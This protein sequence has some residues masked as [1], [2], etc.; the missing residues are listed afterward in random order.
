MDRKDWG[1]K[2][3]I[4]K[5]SSMGDIIHALPVLATLREHYPKAEI[6]WIVKDKFSD[7][8]KDNPDLTDIISFD[9]NS[10]LQLINILRKRTFDVALDL[11]GLFRSGI[12]AYFSKASH[13]IGFSKINSREL[14]HIFYNHKVTPS[15]KAVHVV[16]KNLSLLEPLGISEYI[17]DFKIHISTQDLNFAKEFFALKKLFPN[18]AFFYER[19]V[20]ASYFRLLER[21]TKKKTS[22]NY[23]ITLC[24]D[25]QLDSK[26][27]RNYARFLLKSNKREAKLT[28]GLMRDIPELKFADFIASAHRKMEFKKLSKFKH[29]KNCPPKID[30][31]IITRVFEK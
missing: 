5:P 8:L 27:A 4:I 3:L 21:V 20:G 2:I 28:S 19:L 14:S 7:L 9:S 11:Q 31:R 18:K 22:I 10:F 16:D 26:K 15:Q 24:E 30:S 1:E 29:Y 17:Y 25:N 13:R 23:N 6:A 12:L